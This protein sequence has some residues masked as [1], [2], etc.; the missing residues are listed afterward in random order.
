MQLKH[1]IT[2]SV[3]IMLN[4]HGFSPRFDQ[5][6]RSWVKTALHFSDYL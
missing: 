1:K 2:I 6:N 5:E 4:M 3:P